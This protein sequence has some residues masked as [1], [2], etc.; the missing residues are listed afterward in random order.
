MKQF[1]TKF[2]KL[3]FLILLTLLSN[4]ALAQVTACTG[5][6]TY[7]QGGW[8]S[9][10]KGNNPGTILESNFKNVFPFGLTIGSINKISFT[11]ASAVRAFLPQ[12]GTAKR[13]NPGTLINPTKSNFSSV[14]AGQLVAAT[15]NVQFDRSLTNFG[16][17]STQLKDLKIATA[18]F[19]NFTIEEVIA[20]ANS[21][22]GG[23]IS[24][25]SANDFNTILTR[26]NEA[27]DNGTTSN[28]IFA[29]PIVFNTTTTDVKCVGESNGTLSV[30]GVV[31]GAGAPYTFKLNGVNVY[32]PLNTLSVG[33]YTLE[34]FDKLGLS[35][36]KQ[37]L[38]NE[39]VILSIYTNV[40][41][42][43]CH[44]GSTN[45]TVNASG[46]IPPYTGTGVFNK[47]AGNY[48]FTVT[49]ANGCVASTDINITE[50]SLLTLKATPG[51]I[52][53]NGD[54]TDV[55]ILATGG[56]AP[57]TGTGVFNKTAGNY[58][59]TVSDANGCIA[60]TN[61][62]ITEP[63]LLTANATA[64]AI[65]CYGGNTDITVNA[66]GGT[67]PYTGTGVFNKTAGNYTFTVTDANGCVAS[68]DINI[69]EPSLLTVNS[70]AN[71]I[72]CYGGNTDI[73]VNA[74]GG[75][76]PYTGTGVFNKTAGNYTFTV[77]DAN[78]C[79]ASTNINITE[80]T[81]LSLSG[82]TVND[83][84]CNGGATTGKATVSAMG[85]TS[86]YTYAW[87]NGIT[88]TNSI[89]NIAYNTVLT[90]TVSDANGCSS[91][92]N[93]DTIRCDKQIVEVVCN[94]LKTF[95]QGGWGAVPNG[96]NPGVYLHANFS[97]VFPSGLTIGNVTNNIKLTTAT[98]VT[99]FLPS[100]GSLNTLTG[101]TIN[102]A[103]TISS[104]IAGQLVAATLNVGFDSYDAN[105]GN[106]SN[107][108][109]DMYCNFSGFYGV[110]VSD[111][112]A[113]ANQRIA[114]ASTVHTSSALNNAL[115]KLN[116]NYDNGNQ[117]NG[118][119]VCTNS[120]ADRNLVQSTE[121]NIFSNTISIYPN[122]ASDLLN[123]DVVSNRSEI[124]TIN[125]YNTTGQLIATESREVTEGANLIKLNLS[126]LNLQ[127]NTILV[128]LILNNTTQRKVIIIQ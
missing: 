113:E 86:P 70:T 47:T 75:T 33:V 87:S 63:S 103:G 79:I 82:T 124:A 85:G 116:E 35:A 94:V 128:E 83:S 101:A 21:F 58:T 4:N 126:A 12:G 42:I 11:T 127:Y 102:P 18:P 14:L 60:S 111:L 40:G 39:P 45:V 57:Y 78:G 32:L 29:C 53:C 54:S 123:I 20:E 96:N 115:T 120:E 89:T 23:K 43:L 22:I 88:G 46:G 61:I 9:T 34:V 50:P 37:I 44:G 36:K 93:F 97:T 31:G 110:K 24:N 112:L 119:F 73:T 109:S 13:L 62:T 59:F 125:I 7:T 19:F 74:T 30:S 28:S 121:S 106:G 68:T 38:I 117:D 25:Y 99:N 51:A 8:G 105:F 27:Y 26:V 71:A 90:V 55:T 67:A 1:F 64:N 56:T 118:D 6:T 65:L 49:D 77:S 3:Q 41:T 81:T 66:T 17:S 122:P 107:T 84:S 100:G 108:L 69:T 16:S 76:A 95:T 104:T 98:D 15:I 72:L 52:L 80:P 5:F 10:P 114:G 2:I 92:F 48:T 91:T